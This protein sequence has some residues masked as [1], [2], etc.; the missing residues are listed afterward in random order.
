MRK[1]STYRIAFVSDPGSAYIRN[2]AEGVAEF[3]QTE[4]EWE[5]VHHLG[6]PFLSWDQAL[7]SQADGMIA[8]LRKSSQLAFARS[9]PVVNYSGCLAPLHIAGAISDD[10]K[11][12]QEAAAHLASLKLPQLS[13][14][15]DRS[16]PMGS[17]REHAFKNA[18]PAELYY[19]PPLAFPGQFAEKH[20]W[21]RMLPRLR[22]WLL[23]LP[24]PIAVFATH[25]NLAALLLDLCVQEGIAIPEEL[26]ILGVGQDSAAG[27][28]RSIQ[29]SH[30]PLNGKAVGHAAAKQLQRLLLGKDL[31]VTCIQVPPFPTRVEQSTS[32]ARV[33][34][35]LVRMALEKLETQLETLRDVSDLHQ[36]I[37]ISRRGFEIRFRQVL[38]RSP[39]E[40]LQRLR[41]ERSKELLARTRLPLQEIA[42][43]LGWTDGRHL[44]V[45]FRKHSGQSPSAYRNQFDELD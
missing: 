41:I 23:D 7:A 16:G 35:P 3:G 32:Y 24:K 37:P 17:L 2:V 40:E 22:K 1:T 36:G 6:S 43:R 12:S 20:S 27:A 5:F 44:S 45:A 33:Q 42:Q 13:C 38:G 34:D 11:I 10:K 39:Y 19:A 18:L 8:P 21:K 26:C 31:P 9:H 15:I 14:L 4:P 28:F 29:L 30:V 25:N